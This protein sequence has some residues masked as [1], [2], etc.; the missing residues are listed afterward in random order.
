MIS[1]AGEMAEVDISVYPTL[2]ML[3]FRY[4]IHAGTIIT[5]RPL[6]TFWLNYY[7]FGQ[8]TKKNNIYQ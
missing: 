7:I 3:S 6:H 5:L 2:H 4:F 8:G 1:K